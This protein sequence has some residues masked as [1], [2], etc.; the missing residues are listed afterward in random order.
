M[1]K[2]FIFLF[3]LLISHT[4]FGQLFDDDFHIILSNKLIQRQQNISLSKT[5]SNGLRLIARSSLIGHYSGGLFGQYVDSNHYY[6]SSNNGSYFNNQFLYF[7][8]SFYRNNLSAQEYLYDNHAY[9]LSDSLINWDINPVDHDTIKI[10]KRQAI[11]DN[12]GRVHAAYWHNYPNYFHN[13]PEYD[14]KT[15]YDYD[16]AGNLINY[17]KFQYSSLSQTWDT[18]DF[19]RFTYDS[20]NKV[21]ADTLYTYIHASGVTNT[22]VSMRT[23]EY[24]ATGDLSKLIIWLP[25]TLNGGWYANNR[26]TIDYYSGSLLKKVFSEL[27]FSNTWQPKTIDT[28]TYQPNT[29]LYNKWLVRSWQST[30]GWGDVGETI[31]HF[32]NQQL[33]D[34]VNVRQFTFNTGTLEP[35]FKTYYI[36]NGFGLP[37]YSYQEYD[38]TANT[39]STTVFI[40]TRY[41]YNWYT[42]IVETMPVE[43]S[44]KIFPNPSSGIINIKTEGDYATILM[45]DSQGKLLLN[46]HCDNVQDLIQIDLPDVPSSYFII[47]V[48]DAKG[49]LLG[50]QVVVKQ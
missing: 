31:R 32:N 8:D 46:K 47:G 20:A 28:F 16:N 3:V 11:Y 25:N 14:G 38:T 36:Y 48:L 41:Y 26:Y 5:T 23:F 29:S 2:K 17:L 24:N 42:G 7:E 12:L 4:A 45:Y 27:W 40:A 33:P 30:V 18:T 15:T 6:Y 19:Y 9:I 49:K 13:I 43:N 39:W 22:H 35:V 10:Y 1:E 21:I 50:K 37:E 44:I 34:T